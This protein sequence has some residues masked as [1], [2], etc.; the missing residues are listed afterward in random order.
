MS[1]LTHSDLSQFTGTDNWYRHSLCRNIV[2]TDGV[3]YLAETAGAY[4]L[5]DKV[6]TNQLEPKIRREEFQCWRLVVR[7]READLIADD[8]NGNIIHRELIE[9]TDFPLDKI[10]L[11]VEG[12]VILLPSEH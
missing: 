1:T 3:K 8:G 10:E 2:Y 12:N 7:G 4:W 6:A 5:I 11:W 9:F